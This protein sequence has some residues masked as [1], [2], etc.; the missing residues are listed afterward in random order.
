MFLLLYLTSWVTSQDL[1]LCITGCFKL[2]IEIIIVISEMCGNV[3]GPIYGRLEFSI[4]DLQFPP[5]EREYEGL[6]LPFSLAATCL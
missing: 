2:L 3:H 5:P 4:E 6:I 1:I